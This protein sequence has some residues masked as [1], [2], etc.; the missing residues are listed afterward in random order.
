MKASLGEKFRLNIFPNR[1]LLDEFIELTCQVSCKSIQFKLKMVSMSVFTL[2]LESGRE[3]NRTCL[4]ARMRSATTVWC[5]S[6]PNYSSHP[7]PV[8][9]ARVLTPKPPVLSNA[10]FLPEMITWICYGP[11]C[12]SSLVSFWY[13]LNGDFSFNIIKVHWLRYMR[14]SGIFCDTSLSIPTCEFRLW[15]DKLIWNACDV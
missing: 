3:I 15:D 4:G 9:E 7:T 5:C 1:T 12:P 11:L 2:L 10:T 8:T 13:M 6:L 14:M